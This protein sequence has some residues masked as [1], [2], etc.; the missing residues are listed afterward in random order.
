MVPGFSRG[1]TE[2]YVLYIFDDLELS[3]GGLNRQSGD[4]SGIVTQGGNPYKSRVYRALHQT[5]LEI[6]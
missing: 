1:T 6:S 3:Y 5:L 4:C 2:S